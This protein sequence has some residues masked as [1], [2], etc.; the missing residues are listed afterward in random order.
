M[1]AEESGWFD[2]RS[3]FTRLL[4][5]S[6]LLRNDPGDPG[7][8]VL[9]VTGL[10]WFPFLAIELVVL[11]VVG[12]VDSIFLRAAVHV[13]LLVAIPAF[14]IAEFAFATRT[15]ACVRRILDRRLFPPE[16]DEAVHALVS[17]AA[18]RRD[19]AIVAALQLLA[20]I[21]LGQVAVWRGL[22]LVTA[23]ASEGRSA[24]AVWYGFV[25]LPVF[26]ILLLG[27]AWRW[28]IWALLL[29]RLSRLPPR[30]QPMHP[31]RAGGLGFL[32]GPSL[33]FSVFLFGASSVIA[34]TFASS[35]VD[36]GASLSSFGPELAVL[37]V[38]GELLALGP[39][40]VF[41]GRLIRTRLRG[42]ERYGAL[43]IDYVRR[44]H[45]RWIDGGSEEILG[46]PDI[47]SLADYQGAFQTL[48]SMRLIPF[49]RHEMVLVAAALLLPMMAL[50]LVAVPVEELLA[51]LAGML[52]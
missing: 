33:A 52:F 51:R 15:D 49:G 45:E 29:W 47:Q 19:S 12:H 38:V 6:R 2:R 8:T 48:A 36:E 44:F 43:G 39:L 17:W 24:G 10:L 16:E 28:A 13:R 1:A 20:G 35:M 25:V 23:G 22:A 30:L 14:L 27:W 34:A 50:L 37:V 5:A 26:S 40:L 18:R 21:A 4:R 7:R 42:I 9:T 41:S 11:A 31:D 46:T 32:V 3:P